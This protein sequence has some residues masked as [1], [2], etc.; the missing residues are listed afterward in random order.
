MTS[1]KR[2]SAKTKVPTGRP[3]GR[4]KKS[5]IPQPPQPPEVKQYNPKK[6]KLLQGQEQFYW[7]KYNKILKEQGFD[8]AEK[9][10]MK[11]NNKEGKRI[12]QKQKI[13]NRED[14]K[15]GNLNLLKKIN[16]N[17]IE[18]NKKFNENI[19]FDFEKIYIYIN[20]VASEILYKLEEKL[21]E[22]VKHTNETRKKSKPMKNG[23]LSGIRKNNTINII[24]DVY[25]FI[26]GT[27]ENGELSLYGEGK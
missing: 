22:I 25:N 12:L 5:S 26:D 24:K 2:H 1:T 27:K 19:S 6:Y 4:P 15:R 11:E 10:Q 18:I 16:K 14:I 23:K 8:E 20:S 13:I 17:I 9:Y 21:S 7:Q 3:R